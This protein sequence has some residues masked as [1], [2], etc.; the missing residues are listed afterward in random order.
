MATKQ[1]DYTATM[2]DMMGAFPVDTKAMEDAFK[3]QASLSEKLSG[4]VL[5][6]AEKSAEISSAWP[7]DIIPRWPKCPR[8]RP[9]RP[10]MPRR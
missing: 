8:P 2:K 4:V 3:T 6:A 1:Q 5:E 10:T 7:K 9:S